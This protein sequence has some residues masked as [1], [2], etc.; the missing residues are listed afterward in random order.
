[1]SLIER[2]MRRKRIEPAPGT[3]ARKLGVFD[4]MGLGVGAT[5]GAGVYV[6][7]GVIAKTEAGPG[8][9]LSF[10]IS[11]FASILSGL[12]YAEFGARVPRAGSAYV[13]SYVTVGELLAWTTGWQLLLE[14]VIGASSVARSW[15]GYVD[16]LSNGAVTAGIAKGVGAWTVPGLATEPDFLGAGMTMAVSLLVCFGVKESTTVNNLLTTI[17]VCVILFVLV[18]GGMNSTPSNFTSHG[19]FLPMGFN[20]VFKG[21]ATSFYAYVGFDVIATS[22]EEAINPAKVIPVAII[23]SLLICACLYMGVSAVVTMMVPWD[24][25]DDTAPLAAAFA[26]HGLVWAKYVIAIGA[27]CGLSTSLMTCIFPMPR[28]IYAIAEDGLLPPWVGKVS[29][30]FNTPVIATLL[31]GT[32]AAV[33]CLIFDITAL[34]DMMSIGTLMSYTLVAASVLVLRYVEDDGSAAL[35]AA[36][37][38]QS[39]REGES[40]V[41]LAQPSRPAAAADTKPRKGSLTG[42]IASLGDALL[43]KCSD[44]PSADPMKRRFY[45]RTP[46]EAAGWLIAFYASGITVASISSVVMNDTPSMGQGVVVTLYVLIAIA[47]AFAAA[48]VA[49]LLALPSKSPEGLAFTC[50][51]MPWT[52]LASMAINLYLLMSLSPLTWVRFAVWCVIGALIYFGYGIKHSRAPFD[53]EREAEKVKREEAAAEVEGREDDEDDES[54]PLRGVKVAK[55]LF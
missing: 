28:I 21:A 49:M 50:P 48:S 7:T 52:P 29:K 41:Q 9:V 27:I 5:L 42:G 11:G 20:G 17:N 55:Q 22:A 2:F 35:R 51:L 18:V 13:Y 23:S 6:L 25:L 31:C 46:A 40:V 8:I 26:S 34:A 30:R 38:A 54:M 1:M 15:S 4:L 16:A 32:F 33:M 39:A 12:C 14:Y 10:L 24:Q 19:G 3:L 43:S 47:L 37:A 36:T 53:S 44:G 45:G